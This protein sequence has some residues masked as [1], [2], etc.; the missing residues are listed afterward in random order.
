M[1]EKWKILN[2]LCGRSKEKA[3]YCEFIINKGVKVHN[4]KCIAD[5]FNDFYINVG[6]TLANKIDSANVKLSYDEFLIDINCKSSMFVAPTN[7]NEVI[8]IV[9]K[10]AS[11]SSQDVYGLNMKVIK[12]IMQVIIKPFTHIC[13]MSLKSG[14]FPNDLKIA[15]VLPLFKSGEKSEVSNYRPVSILPQLSKIIEKLFEIRL[16]RYIDEKGFLFKGQYGFRKNHSTNLALNEMV[17]MIVDALDNKMYSIGVF[18]DL[19]KAFDTV[20]H[21]LLID[22]FRYYGIRGIASNFLKSYLSNRTQFVKYKDT[23]SSKQE[24]LCGVPQGSILGPL[25]FILY[26]NDMHKVSELLHFIIFADDTNIFYLDKNPNRLVSVIN[27]ELVKLS[28]WFKLNKLSLNVQKSNYMLFSNK[29]VATLPIKL[30]GVELARVTFTKFLGVI[31]DEKFTWIHHIE[32]VKKKICKA[33]G[34]MY[35]IRDKVDN[36][37]LLM[38]YNALI[39]PYLMYCCELWGNTYCIRINRLKLLQKRAVRKINNAEYRD[40]TSA[41]FKK[42]R[43]LKLEDLITLHTCLVMY[44]ASNCLLPKNVQSQFV[45]K[46]DIHGYNTRKKG[47]LHKSSVNSSLKHMSTN[48]RGVRLWNEIDCKIRNSMSINVFKYKL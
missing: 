6:P 41:L 44:K 36:D 31:I 48:I 4:E 15:K 9:S 14:V 35:R 24:V 7:E 42:Y 47:E 23:V 5:A 39:L 27:T 45:K 28:Q 8:N 12:G 32:T 34:S 16:R 19:K 40:H 11:K 46:Q 25:L 29:K 30:D 20:D 22:K 21:E 17:N 18:I 33:I 2:K 38:I 3:K 43:I 13:N 1:K 10:F 37:S 26:I